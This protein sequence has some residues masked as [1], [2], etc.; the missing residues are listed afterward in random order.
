MASGARW[1]ARTRSTSFIVVRYCVDHDKLLVLDFCF[2]AF[3]KVSGQER[4]DAYAILEDSGVRYI[5]MEDTGK[6]WPL[7]D[8]KCVTIMASRSL[9]DDIYKIVTSVLLNVSPFVLKL[10]TQYVKD[11]TEDN[12]SSVRD[13]LDVNRQCARQYLEGT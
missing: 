8:A 4:C 10:V 5:A 1:I 2:A 6:T 9:N 11:S 13:L 12:S 3:I 7:Q